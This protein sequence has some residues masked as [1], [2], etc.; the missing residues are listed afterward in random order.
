MT[1]GE[2]PSHSHAA[3]TNS[4]GTHKH[5]ITLSVSLGDSWG[6]YNG[7]AHKGR[8]DD[9]QNKSEPIQNAGAHSHTVT[10]N[11]TGNN[12]VH[13]NLPPYVS[14]YIFKRTS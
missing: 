14:V 6:D 5:N 8:G 2:L 3:S 13:N 4:A 1:V 9:K 7:A 10:V 11:S 12:Q